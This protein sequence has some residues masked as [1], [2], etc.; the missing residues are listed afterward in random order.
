MGKI[1]YDINT[2]NQNQINEISGPSLIHF[3]KINFFN[4]LIDIY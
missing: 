4:L 1:Y 3:Q 2:N